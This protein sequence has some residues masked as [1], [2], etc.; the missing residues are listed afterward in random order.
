MQNVSKKIG[1]LVAT[2]NGEIF[3]GAQLDSL[4]NQTH[5]KVQGYIQVQ[6]LI[7]IFNNQVFLLLI[8]I[9]NLIIL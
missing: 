5:K 7:L 8:N 6:V 2:F 1:I 4:L 9:I 3:L